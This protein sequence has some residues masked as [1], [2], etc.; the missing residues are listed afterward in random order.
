MTSV[1]FHPVAD[2]ELLEATEWYVERSAIATA[3]A[4]FLREIVTHHLR[5]PSPRRGAKMK[6]PG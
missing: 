1:K 2:A 6:T 4:G 3:A 5:R